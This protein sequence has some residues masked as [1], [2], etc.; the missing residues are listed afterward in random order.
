[1]Q[2]TSLR[3]LYHYLLQLERFQ[4]SL[5]AKKYRLD[6]SVKLSSA[7]DKC[8][9]CLIVFEKFV[10]NPLK[11]YLMK[12]AIFELSASVDISDVRPLPG[13]APRYCPRGLGP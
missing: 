1:M 13:G 9:M 11:A 8:I 5:K 6:W 4:P 2:V 7:P 12:F 3:W 10:F